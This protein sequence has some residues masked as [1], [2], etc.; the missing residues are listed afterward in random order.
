MAQPDNFY[1]EERPFALGSVQFSPREAFI[2]R[3]A[4]SANPSMFT[5]LPV[6]GM[7]REIVFER[8]Q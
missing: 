4:L 1:T 2:R 6:P 7:M 5:A 3:F 8:V